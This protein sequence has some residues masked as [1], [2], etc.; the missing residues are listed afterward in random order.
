MSSVHLNRTHYSPYWLAVYDNSDRGFRD[1]SADEGVKR[2]EALL[3]RRKGKLA[4]SLKQVWVWDSSG[5]I[6]R[7][8][9]HDS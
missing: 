8:L 9:P 3:A 6:K 1:L 4:P 5:L 7:V 2:I